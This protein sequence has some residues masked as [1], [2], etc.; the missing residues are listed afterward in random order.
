MKQIIKGQKLSLEKELNSN[1]FS[2][3]FKWEQDSNKCEI[4]TSILLLSE[5]GK[6]EKEENFIFYNNPHDQNKSVVLQNSSQNN[7]KKNINIDLSKI[8]SDV[9]KILCVMTVDNT[10]DKSYA[11]GNV[12]NI[13]A[14]ICLNSSTI[15]QYQ[16]EGLTKE[17]AFIAIEIYKHNQEWKIQAVGN[18]FNAG[19]DVILKQYSSENVSLVEETPQEVKPTIKLEKI[20]VGSIDFVKKHTSRIDLVKKEIS[21]QKLDNTKA[22]IIMVVDISFSMQPLF[23]SGLVQDTF[24]RVLPLAMQ[25]DDDGSVD[26]WLFHDETY[27]HPNN[28][29]P[30]NRENFVNNEIMSAIKARYGWGGTSYAPAFKKVS[31]N[32]SDAGKSKPPAFVLFFTDGNCTD[33]KQAEREIKMASSYGVFWKFIGLGGSK[34][35]FAFLEKLDDLTDRVIDNADFIHIP[36]LETMT[37]ENLYKL[38]LQEFSSWLTNAKKANIIF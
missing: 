17:T 23:K 7:Y 26:V 13:I 38:L 25:F 4:D 21:L 1:L 5:R 3:G 28:Y 15:L 32:Y 24:D 35:T 22:Q 9:F 6:L 33:K 10:N 14:D 16:I 36:K 12:K 27:N 2:V 20:P 8:P 11:F 31:D 19:L 37:D 29:T 18:G 34:N 30:D